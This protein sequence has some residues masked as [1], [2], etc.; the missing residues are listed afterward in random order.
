MDDADSFEKVPGAHTEQAPEE[1]NSANVPGTHSLH[2]VAPSTACKPGAQGVHTDEL[3]SEDDPAGQT[4]HADW[5]ANA[6]H[7]ASQYVQLEAAMSAT[8]LGGQGMH[9]CDPLIAVYVPSGHG[10]STAV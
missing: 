2:E 6:Y 8:M 5:S 10:I 4:S 7:P 9:D 3:P 1:P